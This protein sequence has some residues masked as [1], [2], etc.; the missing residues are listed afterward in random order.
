[1]ND[2]L[3][4]GV[5]ILMNVV[6]GSK[7]LIHLDLSSTGL[8]PRGLQTVFTGLYLNQS[9]VSLDI[10]TRNYMKKNRVNPQAMTCL[11]SLLMYNQVLAILGLRNL[12]MTPDCVEI[13][14]ST[15]PASSLVSLDFSENRDMKPPIL[16]CFCLGIR[17]SQI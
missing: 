11:K 1:M 2:L 9:I 10:G 14:A 13:L 7:S 15:L 8:T 3:D 4:E 6:S 17:V 12:G 5:S 16:E